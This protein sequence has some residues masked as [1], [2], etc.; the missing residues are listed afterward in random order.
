MVPELSVSFF[1][2]LLLHNNTWQLG[3]L[4]SAR[5]FCV[6]ESVLH[7]TDAASL[8]LE[9]RGGTEREIEARL[10]IECAR[11]FGKDELLV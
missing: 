3:V 9:R 6:S 11:L 10:K 7:V 1:T 8:F 5:A 2:T 4:A